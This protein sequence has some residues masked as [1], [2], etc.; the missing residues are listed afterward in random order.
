MS[1]DAAD[2]GER[3]FRVQV[4][5]RTSSL[6]VISML[7]KPA[8]MYEPSS[9]GD[10]TNLVVVFMTQQSLDKGTTYRVESQVVD[11]CDVDGETAKLYSSAAG[12]RTPASSVKAMHPSRWTT[13]EDS[14]IA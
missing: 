12:S 1:C 10:E 7:S 3:Y 2:T 11:L 14:D 4:I 6:S 9:S 8:G 5:A 13:A